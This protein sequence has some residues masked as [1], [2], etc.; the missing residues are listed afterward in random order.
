VERNL[1]EY[2]EQRIAGVGAF[3]ADGRFHPREQ[4]ARVA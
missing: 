1:F 4:P 2:I 3:G